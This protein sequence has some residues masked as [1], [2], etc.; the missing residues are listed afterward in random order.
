MALVFFFENLLREFTVCGGSL[1]QQ[2]I[3]LCRG[4]DWG[5]V[6]VNFPEF[7]SASILLSNKAG[8]A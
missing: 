3:P 2:I 1:I 5:G 8:L 7:H 4:V 6:S